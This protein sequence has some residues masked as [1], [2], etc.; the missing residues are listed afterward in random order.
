MFENFLRWTM[1]PKSKRKKSSRIFIAPRRSIIKSENT[2]H[3]ADQD[4]GTGSYTRDKYGNRNGA[5]L[6]VTTK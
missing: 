5:I 1:N 2:A 4:G 3:E 6:Y